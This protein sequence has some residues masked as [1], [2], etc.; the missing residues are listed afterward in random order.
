[1]AFPVFKGEPMLKDFNEWMNP[2]LLATAKEKIAS[3]IE[4]ALPSAPSELVLA[5]KKDHDD[6]RDLMKELKGDKPIAAKR[7]TYRRFRQLLRSHSRAEEKAVYEPCLEFRDLRKETYEG[8]TE[9][10][11]ADMLMAKI[12]SIRKAPKWEAAV[13]VLVE[14]MEHHLDEEERDLFPLIERRLPLP[15]KLQAEAQ[16]LEMRQDSPASRQG[17]ARQMIH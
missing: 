3:A 8:Y 4:D 17:V 16:F 9:H 6:L 1:M 7:A 11:V 14:M 5:L 2:G 12:S 13:E 15:T 10:D